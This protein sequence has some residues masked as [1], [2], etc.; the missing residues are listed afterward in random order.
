MALPGDERGKCHAGAVTAPTVPPQAEDEPSPPPRRRPSPREAVRGVAGLLASAARRPLA[1]GPLAALLAALAGLAVLTIPALLVWMTAAGVGVVGVARLGV[2]TWVVAHGVPAVVDGVTISLL[3]WG[4]LLV[5]AL[6][7]AVV[8]RWASRVCAADDARSRTVLLSSAAL[9]YGGLVA[10]AAA[11]A[12]LSVLGALLRGTALAGVVL[13]LVVVGPIV[14]ARMPSWLATPL[15][16]GAVALV[17]L[18]GVGAVLATAGLILR[19]DDAV[20]ML[21]ALDAGVAGGLVIALLGIAFVPVLA[22]WGTSYALGAGVLVGPD[23]VISPLLQSATPT[24][25]P[26]FP[27]LAALPATATPFAWALPVLGVAAG[28]LAGLVIARSAREEPRLNR[29]VLAVAAAGLAALGMLVL[30][31]LASGSVGED[32]LSDLGPPAAM[33]AMLAFVLVVIGAVPASVVTTPAG[34]PRLAV[35]APD[36]SA[37]PD[38]PPEEGH[39]HV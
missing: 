35:A 13:A 15:R 4:L 6:A 38:G 34:K 37:D 12:G 21:Q 33:V 36:A 10:L 24:Q 19:F 39:P 14:R 5:P 17:G 11:W 1:V 16:A 3:P 28:A 20:A 27:L 31:L 23:V 26:P 32:R 18:L 7:L 30:A 29:A 9:L 25:L 22:V 8:G 2:S